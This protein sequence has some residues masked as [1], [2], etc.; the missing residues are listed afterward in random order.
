MKEAS[1]TKE[2]KEEDQRAVNTSYKIKKGDIDG[3]EKTKKKK[4]C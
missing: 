4:C 1:K 2:E 3:G